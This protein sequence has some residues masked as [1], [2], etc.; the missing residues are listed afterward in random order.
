MSEEPIVINA[1]NLILGRLASYV[2]KQ[3]LEGHSIVILN[4]EKAIIS[5]YKKSIIQEAKKRLSTRTLGSQK[6]APTHPRRPDLYVRRTI[7]GMLPRK[8]TKGKQAF[9]RIKVYMNIPEEYVNKTA[10][11]IPEADA[12]KLHHKHIMVEDLSKEIG[13]V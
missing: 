12:S 1:S 10:L 11:K 2:A 6:K 3:A 5:G 9:E 7:R 13:G 4:A 8:K